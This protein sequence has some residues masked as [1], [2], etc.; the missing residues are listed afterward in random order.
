MSSEKTKIKNFIVLRNNLIDELDNKKINKEEFIQKNLK[1][2][3]N[4]G[5]KPFASIEDYNMGI[6]NYQYYNLM[7]KYYN[8]LSN[9]AKLSKNDKK[10][11]MYKNMSRNY[12]NEKD[13]SIFSILEIIQFLNVEA[14]FIK[15]ESKNL[16]SRLF[17]IWV[18]DYEKTIF[19]SMNDRLLEMLRENNVF[20]EEIRESLIKDYINE[21]YWTL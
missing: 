19:H 9:K 20:I 13:K 5:I 10:Y 6:F 12:Y 15:T 8:M 18:K 3:D 7:A 21:L 11:K 2:L 4:S 17:E 1:I 14:Y 16:N